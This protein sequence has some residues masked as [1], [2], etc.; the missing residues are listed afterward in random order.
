MESSQPL[1]Q[2]LNSEPEPQTNLES[3]K[4]LVKDSGKKQLA[5]IAAFLIIAVV[6]G[7]TVFAYTQ[8]VKKEDG[9]KKEEEEVIDQSAW[10]KC[11]IGEPVNIEVKVPSDWNCESGTGEGEAGF[12]EGR[13]DIES[14]EGLKIYFGMPGPYD[15]RGES[16]EESY[17]QTKY[18]D[19]T[20]HTYMENEVKKLAMLYGNVKDTDIVS[21]VNTNEDKMPQKEELDIIS[22]I[23]ETLVID[24]KAITS[25]TF[26]IIKAGKTFEFE[27]DV[28]YYAEEEIYEAPIRDDVSGGVV[29]EISSYYIN[30]YDIENIP[31]PDYPSSAV[32]IIV[33]KEKEL[34][35]GIELPENLS[36]GEGLLM[37]WTAN[38]CFSFDDEKY[39][40]STEGERIIKASGKFDCVFPVEDG[41]ID[42]YDTEALAYGVSLDE[43]YYAVIY[44]ATNDVVTSINE[45]LLNQ[46]AR[47]I[48]V[49]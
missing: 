46:I 33:N 5:F 26:S 14:P 37:T 41:S 15:T 31:S 42:S 3:F 24:E 43:E 20:A 49:K 21:W 29:E 8:L 35:G 9:V 11:E 16:F 40:E 6:L 48:K 47:T 13:L 45:D 27:Y 7:G 1:K 22:S 34:E 2:A 10:K 18:V 12:V 30:V 44:I 17:L 36:E 4:K 23:V 39:F 25:K 19:Y 28:N 32:V 38:Q